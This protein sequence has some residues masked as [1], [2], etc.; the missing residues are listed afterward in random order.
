[1]TLHFNDGWYYSPEFSE[2]MIFWSTAEAKRLQRVRLPHTVRE[3]PLSYL[4]EQD[5]QMVSA[6]LHPLTVPESWEGKRVLLHFGAAAHEATIY[7]NG[8]PVCT[9]RCGY[10]A[11]TA[12]LT[13]HL[14]PGEENLIAVR[15][16]SR[17]SLDQP[18]FGHVIDYLTYGG[19]Y[20]GVTLEIAERSRIS[21][22]FIHADH[23]GETRM[24]IRVENPGSLR[25]TGR[26][27]G[28]DGKRLGRLDGRACHSHYRMAVPRPPVWSIDT[29]NL[30]TL[31][32]ELRDGEQILDRRS[33]RFGFR[34]VFFG[35]EGFF[36]NGEYV[37]LRGL[38]RHQSWPYI[39][40]AAPDRAQALDADILKYE[41]GCN[42]V[43][44]SH[45]PQSHAFVSRCDEIGL[46]VF[47]EIPGWQ[48]IGGEKWQ[49]LCVENVREM[50]TEY[51][52]HPSIILWGVRI[53]ES[54]DCDELYRRTNAMA[55]SLDPSRPTGG[56]RNFKKRTSTPTTTLS[57]AAQMP[58]ASRKSGSPPTWPRAI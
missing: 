56:V 10:T 52:N 29:P 32:L 25:L 47:T 42:I 12:E 55:H 49:D 24:E 7:C 9:H 22:V 34:T 50:V 18:P 26:V 48:H 31:E 40:Y 4:N 17:E 1:M 16:D 58:A 3:L 11:F 30:C 43:R 5:Y 39:G 51:R 15:L 19:L 6:Y 57:T 37:K 33:V 13:E 27:L 46:L 21:D 23:R 2:E 8:L 20:R 28:P 45:Y 35:D 41:L 44:T 54:A 53:N 14:R 36:L 38:N